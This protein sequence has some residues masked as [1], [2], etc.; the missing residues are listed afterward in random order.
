MEQ[1]VPTVLLVEDDED[2]AVLITRCFEEL[3]LAR[4]SWTDDGE[5]AL[6]YLLR[7][8]IY[9]GSEIPD[10]ILIDLR[11]PKL[12]GHQLLERIKDCEEL[13]AVPKIVL[14]SSSNLPDVSRAYRNSANSYLVKPL[15]F[16]EFKRMIKI[17]GDYWLGYNVA[18]RR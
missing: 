11:L 9:A 1:R 17:L 18:C 4:I 2:H 10:L 14:S 15:G 13:T 3:G 8:G 12:D 6:D 7:R 16:E 5:K